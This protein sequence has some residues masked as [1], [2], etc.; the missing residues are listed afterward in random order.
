MERE[1]NK[2]LPFLDV[3]LNNKS[4]QFPVTTVD[5]EKTLTGSLTNFLRFTPLCY[6]MGL[7]KTVIDRT[8]KSNNTWLGFHDD[9]QNL[10]IILSKI[11]IPSIY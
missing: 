9:I 2:V 6:K 3:L 10:F 11:S 7:F 4:P 1:S 5:R 8:F